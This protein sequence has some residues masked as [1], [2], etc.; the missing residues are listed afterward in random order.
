MV[1]CSPSHNSITFFLQVL[2][3]SLGVFHNLLGIG[4]VL[5]ALELSKGKGQSAN[6]VDVRASLH[7]G[8]HAKVDFVRQLLALGKDDTTSGTSHHLVS[9]RGDD[10]GIL[11]GVIEHSG[12]HQAAVVGHVDHEKGT[13]L[14]S[15]LSESLVVE[16]VAVSR[17]AS[18]EDVRLELK[19]NLFHL[20]VVNM[21]SLLVEV[22]SSG[23]EEERG[24]RDVLLRRLEAMAQM[25]AVLQVQAEDSSVLA[26]EASVNCKVGW[27][28]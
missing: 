10:I 17:V 22:V 6:L 25:A 26:D 20:L 18:D 11:K 23:L 21:T 13:S 5:R 28:A 3:E 12:G 15:Y 8:E 1:D 9:G 4:S 16:V 27:A 2:A 24:R 14:V 19:G 7:H